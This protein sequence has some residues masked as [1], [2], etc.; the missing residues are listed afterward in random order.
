MN[1]EKL[2]AFLQKHN[3]PKFRLQ[4]IQKAVF[5]ESV[6]SFS[7]ISTLN[8][9]MRKN[10]E[11][12]MKIL[13]FEVEKVLASKDEK[14]M[15]ALL[16]L[17]DENLI[18]AVLISPLDGVWSA[19][20][21]SQVGCPLACEF[22]STGK[23]GFIRNL[24][25]EEITD[26]ILFWNQQLKTKKEKVSN[27]VYMGMGEP[28][29]NWEEVRKSLADLI[30]EKKFNFASRSISV[31]TSG[32]PEGIEKLSQ[33]FPQVN[34]ALSLHFGSEARRSQIMPINRK[35]NLEALRQALKKYLAVTKRK[36]FLEYVM[37][38][39]VNDSMDDADDLIRFVKSVEKLQLMH[40]NLIRYNSTESR[41]HSSSKER[42]LKFKEYLA[43]HNL[44]VTIRK[45]LGEEIQGACGQLAAK[46]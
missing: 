21:S 20:V 31:S 39:G 13:S 3:Q 32:I 2:E 9:D 30:D 42:T 35:N 14:S 25:A 15:K 34:L 29:L 18:E 10:L 8:K 5:Q 28:F 37:L 26:Q 46:K 36:I 40:V 45:S 44:G 27:I 43:S 19:C 6:S 11:Q 23:M 12:E 4:Q 24:A 38:S 22:C 33:E 1:I 41:F 16:K 17:K 7:E